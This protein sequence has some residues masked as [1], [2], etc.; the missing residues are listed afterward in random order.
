[1]G[2][3]GATMLTQQQAH[4]LASEW[5]QAWNSHNL[6]EILSHYAEDIVLVSPIA[7]KLLNESSGT[8]NGKTAL[9]AYFKKGLEVYPTLRFELVDVLWGVRSMVF[10]YINQN[11]TKAGELVEVDLTGKITRV[12]A[13]Y[14]G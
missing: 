11:E 13:N 1:M 7:A 9:R 5:I 8:V 4:Q 12:I 10:Y 6:D 3:I 2:S 14:N